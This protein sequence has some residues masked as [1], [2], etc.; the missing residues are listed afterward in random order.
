M[1]T[2][3]AD[4]AGA[5]L[6]RLGPADLAAIHGDGRI[7]AHVLRLERPHPQAAPGKGP[8]QAG[9]QQGLAGVRAGALDHQGGRG[10]GRFMAARSRQIKPAGMA[11]AMLRHCRRGRP[12]MRAMLL[13]APG[14]ALRLAEVAQ[15]VP[16]AGQVLVRVKA[17][18]V[19]RTDLH[20]VDGDL[21]SPSC[22]W[23]PAT[24]SSAR[25]WPAARATRR[26]A[27]ASASA[28][29]GSATPA[30]SAPTAGAGRE[31]LCDAPGFT[32]Y[33]STAAMPSTRW[34][35][36]RF[37]FPLP[38][39]YGDAEA[40]PLLCAGLIGYRALRMAG[41][42]R[43]LGIY[44]FGAAAHIVAQVARHEG[45]RGLR[46]HPPRRCRGPGLRPRAWERSGPAT[47]DSASPGAAGRGH[48]LRPRR[49]PGAGGPG[50]GPQGR[51]RRLRRHP[52]ERHPE[53][54]LPPAV[55]G[56]R[57]PLGGQPDPPRMRPSSSTW[58]AGCRSG[59]R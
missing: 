30:A 37:C 6:Q 38:A 34:P 17:C 39:G 59:P 7:V 20:V 13:D 14:R 51:R 24:R 44:G 19:C 41:D 33:T 10:H 9:H 21:P 11:S 53:L 3:G 29:P 8:A 58:P 57:G 32:G 36:P 2:T 43:T 45:R 25:S 50:R 1:S 23:S 52:H 56:A 16:G 49:Q 31:N 35:M 42:A 22:R 12:M 55:G 40:A 54:P 4:A 47:S 26:S 18:A 15:P 27:R 48:H 46:L 28:Y 5:R